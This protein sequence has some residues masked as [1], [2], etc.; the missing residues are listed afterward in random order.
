MDRTK[1]PQSRRGSSPYFLYPENQGVNLLEHIST[2]IKKWMPMSMQVKITFGL[3]K[4]LLMIFPDFSTS[5]AA[6]NSAPFDEIM[7][8]AYCQTPFT[9]FCLK[10]KATPAEGLFALALIMAS[11]TVISP[12]GHSSRLGGWDPPSPS[13]D[14][15]M[16]SMPA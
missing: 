13:L 3:P 14:S 16:W 15:I 7:Q 8:A 2:L 1:D 4:C 11:Q 10:A 9:N 6:F 12:P 5:W